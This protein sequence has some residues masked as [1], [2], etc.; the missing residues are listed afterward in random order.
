VTYPRSVPD[1]PSA[2]LPERLPTPPTTIR[3]GGGLTA[4]EG[5]VSLVL[6]V[7]LVA[8]ELSSSGDGLVSGYGIAVW[9]AAIGA[10]VLAAGVSLV[11]GRRGGRAPATIVQVVLLPVVWSLLTDSGQPVLG[12]ALGV[13]VV[14]VL[15][16]LFVPSSLT[17]TSD[18]FAEEH[19]P[20]PDGPTP[21]VS[22]RG[23]RPGRADRGPRR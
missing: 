12:A 7:V 9:F 14:A 17:W 13:V 8:R 2:P 3:V 6:A 16:L 23:P 11:R 20:V 4:L 22:P 18:R 15:V 1:A 21:P 19:P 5:L 10:G